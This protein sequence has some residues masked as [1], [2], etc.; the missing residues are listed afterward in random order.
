MSIKDVEAICL[1]LS[2]IDAPCEWGDDAFLVK[3][4]TDTGIVGWGE[5][6]TSPLVAKAMVDA[7]ESNLYCGGLKRLILG[8]DPLE[9]QKL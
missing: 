6:D 7:P 1:C 3:I 8:E 9:I 2:V 5:S 4:T